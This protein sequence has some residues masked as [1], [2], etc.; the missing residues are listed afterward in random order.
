[1][2]TLTV[3]FALSACL[4]SWKKPQT[5]IPTCSIYRSHSIIIGSSSCLLQ[6]LIISS[7]YFELFPALSRSKYLS[8]LMIAITWK[9]TCFPTK[10]DANLKHLEDV[11]A[12]HNQSV[13]KPLSP[14]KMAAGLEKQHARIWIRMYK[15]STLCL[16]EDNVIAAHKQIRVAIWWHSIFRARLDF[17]V[18]FSI[19]GCENCDLDCV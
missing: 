7:N 19:G 3:R 2:F 13:L 10:E 9:D 18:S 12:H 16:P 5:V 1:M 15:W 17:V 11:R 4:P 14:W 6:I 8:S